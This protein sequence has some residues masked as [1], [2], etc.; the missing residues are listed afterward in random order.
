MPSV[1]WDQRTRLALIWCEW[2][3]L[4]L[5]IFV[6]VFV[7]GG[8]NPILLAA[9]AI[10]A[11]YVLGSTV[12][13]VEWFRRPLILDGAVVVGVV[14]TMLAVTLTGSADSPYVLLAITPTLWAGFF[15]GARPA[16]SAALLAS[17]MLWLIE[18]SEEA[19]NLPGVLLISGIQLLMAITITQV[20]RLLGEVQSRDQAIEQEQIASSRRISQLQ[21]AHDLLA[22]LSE[23][24]ANQETNPIK[25]GTTA[26]ESLVGRYPATAAAAA[27]SSTKGPV[28]VARVGLEPPNP[29]RVTLPLKAGGKET[30]WVMLATQQPFSRAEIH[31][32]EDSLRPLALAFSNVLLLQ[33]IAGKAISEERTRIA[34]DLHDDLGPSLASLGLSLDLAMVQNPPTGPLGEQLSHLRRSVSYLVDDIRRTVADLRS[35]PEPSLINTLQQSTASLSGGPDVIVSIDERRPPRPSVAQELAAITSEAVRNA[36]NHAE[37]SRILVGGVVD[38]DRG[39]LTIHDDGVGFDPQAVGDGHYGIIGMRERAQKIGAQLAING[40]NDGTTVSIEWGP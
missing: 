33:E 21:N 17:G 4:A 32:L 15:G 37:A 9:A 20:R 3:A 5:G 23:L 7:S 13:P 19:G 30:G 34:R 31:E 39:W 2:I 12:I 27:I 18:L 10:A 1:I 40:G 14:L 24:T 22:R 16:F 11:T 35:E 26:L 28:L 8:A 25:L 36:T 29:H 6:T 38:F